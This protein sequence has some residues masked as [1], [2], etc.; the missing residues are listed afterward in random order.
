M[1]AID[2]NVSKVIETIGHCCMLHVS[3]KLF[4][5]FKVTHFHRERKILM[6]KRR[7]LKKKTIEDSKISETLITIDQKISASHKDEKLH[8]EQV[9]VN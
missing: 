1:N 3:L 4:K 8:D 9:A 5:S 7:K 2:I 6:R